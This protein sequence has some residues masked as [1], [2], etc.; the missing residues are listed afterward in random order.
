MSKPQLKLVCQ[1]QAKM[2]SFWSCAE[3]QGCGD[4]QMT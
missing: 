1:V 4:L 2:L 3:D